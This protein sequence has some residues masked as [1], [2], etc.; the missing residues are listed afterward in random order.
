LRSIRNARAALRASYESVLPLLSRHP[1][2]TRVTFAALAMALVLG[3]SQQGATRAGA[4]PA[5]PASTPRLL[6]TNVG[7]GIATDQTL[8]IQFDQAMDHASVAAALRISPAQPVSLGWSPDG[9]SVRIGPATRW[10]TDARYVIEVPSSSLTGW[11]TALGAPKRVSFTT[12]TAPTIVDFQLRFTPA[13]L[14]T[15]QVLDAKPD[16]LAADLQAVPP[17]DT[18]ALV[19]SRTT[20]SIAFSAPMD[21]TATSRS[22]VLSPAVPGSLTWL[23]NTM[24]F[25]PAAPLAADTR[26]AVS[27]ANARD[28]EGNAIGGDTSFSF[29]TR[30]GA[31]IVATRPQAGAKDVTGSTV[32]LRFSQ[33]M[34]TTLTSR[35]FRV[36]DA[37]TGGRVGGTVS[38]NAARTQ[39]TFT[40]DD[41]FAIGRTFKVSVLSSAR[42]A[43]GNAIS[44]SF[45]FRTPVPVVVRK[46]VV[47]APTAAPRP[48]VPPPAPSASAVGYALN[49]VNA[50]R[51]AYGF[52]PLALDGAVS[53]VANAHAW[54]MLRYGYF[55]HTGRDGSTVRTRL[56]AAGIAYSHAGENI[57]EYGGIGVTAMLQ[58]CHSSFMSEPYPGYANHIGNILDPDFR[59]VG[60]GVAI[61]GGMV[62]VVWDFV[63]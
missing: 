40:A 5:R 32:N 63:G 10:Q 59:R 43:D 47:A 30:D 11:G 57:C 20:I 60:I 9:R 50:A 52:A 16:A 4:E 33:P 18:A 24:T 3:F 48:V 17:A 45:T 62:I 7:V 13:T 46:P 22:F 15:E 6:P 27:L 25:E 54:D 58:W 41:P 12:E 21:T 34:N 38:W 51:A 14:K 2:A 42:D 37:Q 29:T 53:A 39:L 31:Q 61:S 1:A 23:G 35:A 28:A 55:S 49:Q 44:R 36:T 8:T 19:S 26:Y 56:S